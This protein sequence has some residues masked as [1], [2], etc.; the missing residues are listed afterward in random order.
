MAD[1]IQI[2]RDTAA[3][4]TTVNPVLAD[5]E[6]GLEKDTGYWKVGDGSTAWG[7]LQYVGVGP[8]GASAY[9]IAVANGFTGTESE[10]IE[11]IGGVAGPGVPSGGSAG[12]ILKKKS[13]DD[14]DTEWSNEISGFT[15]TGYTES[16]ATPSTVLSNSTGDIMPYEMTANTTFTDGLES[17]QSCVIHLSGGDTYTA[18]WPAGIKWRDGSQPDLS[19]GDEHV[20]TIWKVGSTLYGTDGGGFS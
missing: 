12:K 6:I 14:Y 13:G 4:W 18:S 15:I 11:S 5:G 16:I 1:I 3:N 7:S 17:G 19:D 20:I 2:R 9:E 8:A 10:W